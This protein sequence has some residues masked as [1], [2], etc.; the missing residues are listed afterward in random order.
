MAHIRLVHQSRSDAG[1]RYIGTKTRATP[2]SAQKA[3]AERHAEQGTY[4][5]VG[6][7]WTHATVVV[8]GTVGHRYCGHQVGKVGTGRMVHDEHTIWPRPTPSEEP[9]LH[10]C[11]H[12]FVDTACS[13][14]VMANKSFR[15]SRTPVG[16]F[17][18]ETTS[19]QSVLRLP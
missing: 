15:Y 9:C 1:S 12:V 17:R 4:G 10:D 8:V 16:F 2:C 19:E 6:G 18:N 13:G 11:R 7:L 5:P 3:R 14:M